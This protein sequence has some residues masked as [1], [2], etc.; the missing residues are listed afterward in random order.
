MIKQSMAFKMGTILEKGIGFTIFHH[1][2]I[3]IFV[4]S[5]LVAFSLILLFG[6]YSKKHDMI[7]EALEYMDKAD[8]E[9]LLKRF[10]KHIVYQRVEKEKQWIGIVIDEKKNI[11]YGKR[12]LK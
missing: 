9:V 11:I 6:I 12:E 3:W 5:T 1:S 4:V 10:G 7:K 2:E 8:K